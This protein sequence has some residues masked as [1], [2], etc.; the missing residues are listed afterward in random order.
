MLRLTPGLGSS[1][2]EQ[3]AVNRQV[4]GSA[5]ARASTSRASLLVDR[6]NSS[7]ADEVST[8]RAARRAPSSLTETTRIGGRVAHVGERSAARASARKERTRSAWLREPRGSWRLRRGGSTPQAPS[9]LCRRLRPLNNEAP[10]RAYSSREAGGESGGRR[11]SETCIE[12]RSRRGGGL[13]LPLAG[14]C[15]RGRLVL[16]FS[17][18]S[19]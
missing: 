18:R 14:R 8:V 1:T 7:K 12:A 5:P 2:A 17:R 9:S 19:R 11:R 15:C 10:V 13:G 3:P 6:V 16:F 4:A